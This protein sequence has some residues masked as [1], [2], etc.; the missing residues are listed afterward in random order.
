MKRLLALAAL[1]TPICLFSQGFGSFSHD[2]PFFALTSS[3]SSPFTPYQINPIHWWVHTDANTN[4]A[5]TNAW[6]DRIQGQF[7]LQTTAGSQPFNTST[8]FNFTATPYFS[9]TN[10]SGQPS[11]SMFILLFHATT[12]FQY[13]VA[14][15][16]GG[17]GFTLNTGSTNLGWTGSAVGGSQFIRKPPT[18]VWMDVVSVVSTNSG[19]PYILIYTNGV[20]QLSNVNNTAFL[21]VDGNVTIGA[22]RNDGLQPFN[23]VIREVLFS[24]NNYTDGGSLAAT[25]LHWYATNTYHY[26]P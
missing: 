9:T 26:S 5:K 23:G 7:A 22:R 15:G 2:Q 17:D 11:V 14:F 20:L 21:S 3:S 13:P 24:T 25:N 1:L 4:N 6:I 12:D 10:N 8:G 16:F 18:D 19:L